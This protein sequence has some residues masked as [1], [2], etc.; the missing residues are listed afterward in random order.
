MPAD[1][2]LPRHRLSRFSGKGIACIRGGRVL[3][4][5]LGF[6]VAAGGVLLLTGPNG[7]GKS[8]LL[9]VMAGLLP[10]AGGQIVIEDGSETDAA[11]LGHADQ[12]KPELNVRESLAF[13]SRISGPASSDARAYWL[14]RAI[15]AFALAPLAELQCRRL[16]AGQKRRVALARVLATGRALWLLD[17]PTT[18]LDA[19]TVRAFETALA[20]HRAA[21]GIAVIAT[22]GDIRAEGAATLEIARFA[23]S[24]LS[25]P[26]Y[27]GLSVDAEA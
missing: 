2:A 27:R 24:D 15:E 9:R 12:L 10:K 18:S 1:T 25:D 20:D 19:A 6:E 8:S 4:A 14:E 11:Y 17:E 23:G 5:G 22:H 3:F 7:I 13:W 26:F 16:S 21:G